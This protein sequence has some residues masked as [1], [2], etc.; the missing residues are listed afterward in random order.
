MA[1]FYHWQAA[2]VAYC[3]GTP[4][5][6]ISQVFSIPLASLRERMRAEGWAGLRTKM[7][8]AL[9][10][11]A[12]GGALSV[13][14]EA[15]AKLTLI[16][17]NRQKNLAAWSELREHAVE[18][19]Q[20]LRTGSLKMEKQ[21]HNKGAVVRADVDPGPGDWV[22]IAAYLQTISQGTYRALGDMTAQDKPGQDSPAGQINAPQGPA[23]TIILPGAVAQPRQERAINDAKAGQ[24]IDIRPAVAE[25]TQAA[26]GATPGTVDVEAEVKPASQDDGQ[27]SL[28]L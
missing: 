14:A 3:N 25:L 9:Q 28:G 17:E 26:G 6:E 21:F 13:P 20:A 22:N 4:E 7:P 10:T 12:P 23:I 19:I 15:E 2:F 8:M 1:A 24:V 18:M 5:D 27:V 16:K 11:T